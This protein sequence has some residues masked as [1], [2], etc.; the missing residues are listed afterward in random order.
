[1]GLSLLAQAAQQADGEL[2][3]DSEEGKGTKITAVFQ[4]SHPDTK[5]TGDVLQTMATLVAGNPST[6]FILDYK[7]GDYSYHFDSF[8]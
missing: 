6:Q 5:P 7:R 1:M 2:E 4:L 3:I 8:E